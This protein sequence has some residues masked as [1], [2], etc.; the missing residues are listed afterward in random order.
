MET[1]ASGRGFCGENARVAIRL[2]AM[3]GVP[4]ARIYVSGE[5]WPHVL[6]ECRLD[7][8]WWLFDGHNDPET[9]MTPSE[10]CTVES[11]RI[12]RLRN[13]H[14][15][16]YVGFQRIRLFHRLPV[17]ER[18]ERIRLPQWTILIL[19]SPDLAKA[20]LGLGVTISAL[21]ARSFL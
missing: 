19:E 6:T 11:P 4:S 21:V 20:C 18:L 15:N 8:R 12:E 13:H 10:V 16:P 1:L 2:M 17:L 3:I 5:R 9:A 7:G 14:P